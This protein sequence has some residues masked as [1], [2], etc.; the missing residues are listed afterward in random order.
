MQQLVKKFVWGCRDGVSCRA[1]IG[2]CYAELPAD[3][4]GIQ[5]PNVWASPLIM[6]GS[7]VGRCATGSTG[8]GRLIG[9]ILLT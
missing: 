6:A 1:W 3:E 4:G 8:V 9:D 5:L 7:T 2:E